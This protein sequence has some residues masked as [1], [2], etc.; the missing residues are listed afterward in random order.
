[1]HIISE[2]N[3]FYNV[4]TPPDEETPGSSENPIIQNV[5]VWRMFENTKF[6]SVVTKSRREIP[7]TL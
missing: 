4:V 6:Y 5:F 7:N 3:V 1:M 2:T